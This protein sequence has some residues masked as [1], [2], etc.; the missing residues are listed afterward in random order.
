MTRFDSLLTIVKSNPIVENESPF[1]LSFDVQ[2]SSDIMPAVF[3]GN[4]ARAL[5]NNI[6]VGD[7]IILRKGL[8]DGGKLV[9]EMVHLE[10]NLANI[11]RNVNYYA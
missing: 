6:R 10:K 11:G 9:F 2:V 1:Y 4:F 3:V 7:R 8:V 5:K